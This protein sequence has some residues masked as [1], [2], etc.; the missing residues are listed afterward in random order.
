MFSLEFKIPEGVNVEVENNKIKVSGPLGNLEKELKVSREIKIE[1][2]GNEIKVSCEQ[3]KR[4][5]KAMAGTIIAHL[6]NMVE[7]VQKGFRYKLKI[8]YSHFPVTVKVE[9][10]RVIIQNF[11][12]ERVPRIAK[13]KG[14]VKVE[15]KLPEL[16][17]SGIDIDD[18]SQ[19]AANIE[20][21]CRIK[22]RDRKVFQDGIWIVGRE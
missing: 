20:Q 11:L 1:K 22:A 21:A 3:E 16:F 5:L 14:N 9:G 19:T 8:V 6:R 10:D 7:G 17:V 13:I 12:G 18:V 2:V 15:V 4:K